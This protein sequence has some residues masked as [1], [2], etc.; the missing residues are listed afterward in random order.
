MAVIAIE[1][2]EFFAYHGCFEEEQLIG[3]KFIVDVSF[4]TNTASAE[5]SDKLSDTVNYQQVYQ[6][7]QKEMEHT[8]KLLEHLARRIATALQT[9]FPEITDLKVKVSKMNPPIGGKVDKVSVCLKG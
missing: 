1:N 4:E 2:M 9:G 6:L 3:N 8:S 7:V 5:Q